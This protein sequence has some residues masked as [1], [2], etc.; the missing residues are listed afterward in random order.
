MHKA[1]I[2]TISG[3]IAS[4]GYVQKIWIKKHEILLQTLKYLKKSYRLWNDKKNK[5][6]LDDMI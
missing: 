6:S 2:N 4:N 1:F 3:K 5:A